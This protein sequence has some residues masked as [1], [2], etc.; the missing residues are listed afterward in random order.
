MGRVRFYNP[1][2]WLPG[3]EAGGTAEADV[4]LATIPEAIEETKRGR[5]LL[6]VDDEDRENEG[7]EFEINRAKTD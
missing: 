5:M 6:V 3:A 1:V 2:E 4:P 7:E